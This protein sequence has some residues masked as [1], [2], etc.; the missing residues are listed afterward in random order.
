MDISIQQVLHPRCVHVRSLSIKHIFAMES[1]DSYTSAQQCFPLYGTRS[2]LPISIE[3]ELHEDLVRVPSGGCPARH[4]GTGARSHVSRCV[5][6]SST[7][8]V[9]SLIM[10]SFISVYALWNKERWIKRVCAFALTLENIIVL[11]GFVVHYPGKDFKIL[12]LIPSLQRSFSY[13][14]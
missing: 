12:D 13:Y 9:S 7:R 4:N 10:H 3:L 2:H 8:P 1:T 14:G 11:V 6:P 5:H